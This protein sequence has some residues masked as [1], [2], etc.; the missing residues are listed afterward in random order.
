[1]VLLAHELHKNVDSHTYAKVLNTFLVGRALQFIVVYVNRDVVVHHLFLLAKHRHF[2]LGFAGKLRH[3]FLEDASSS[4][5]YDT[6]KFPAYAFY[7]ISA[8]YL[9]LLG[10]A[11]TNVL[12]TSPISGTEIGLCVLSIASMVVLYVDQYQARCVIEKLREE[13][14]Q[15]RYHSRLKASMLSEPE[16]PPLTDAIPLPPPPNLE[17]SRSG[18]SASRHC[19]NASAPP[20]T[21]SANGHKM[22][23]P[24]RKLPILAAQLLLTGAAPGAGLDSS[25]RLCDGANIDS[26]NSNRL[27]DGANVGHDFE[28]SKDA[29]AQ[30]LANANVDYPSHAFHWPSPVAFV[31]ITQKLEVDINDLWRHL[32]RMSSSF[33]RYEVNQT[34][35]LDS[36]HAISRRVNAID[37]RKRRQLHIPDLSDATA[38]YGGN[39]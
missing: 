38:S 33:E 8:T 1:L 39:K 25:N 9:T 36:L 13:L 22:V 19:A 10:I 34:G 21:T 12:A 27:C 16:D 30:W 32:E 28:S 7:V 2:K 31:Q 20:S 14:I 6:W 17:E 5:S 23:Q 4:L 29:V 11:I 15:Q 18:G 24:S 3:E 26:S 37:Q 35:L